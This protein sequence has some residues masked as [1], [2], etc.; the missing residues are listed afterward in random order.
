MRLRRSTNPFQHFVYRQGQTF[1]TLTANVHDEYQA[2][3]LS[4]EET[5][6]EDSFEGPFVYWHERRRR[7]PRLSRMALDFYDRG[8]GLE[9]FGT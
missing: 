9:L 8:Y 4:H 3:C 6:D 2:W 1:K 5:V 7:Y